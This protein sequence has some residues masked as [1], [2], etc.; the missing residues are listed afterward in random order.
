MGDAAGRRAPAPLG[1]S[2]S[3]I[4]RGFAR[5]LATL[6]PD[7]EVPPVDLLPA[8]RPRVAPYIYSPAEIAAL[9]HAAGQ[10]TPPL[11]AASYRT[12]IGL[13]AATGLRL[14][15]ALGLDRQTSTFTTARC[16][17]APGRPSSARCRCTRPHQGAARVRAPA[18]SALA[19]AAI[20][21]VLPQRRGPRLPIRVQPHLRAS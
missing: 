16:T 17:C 10:L 8:R 11:R 1:G 9:M 4:V 19:A 5:Y 12:V 21:G 3:T 20:A 13:M 18:R 14:G 2:G 6:D 7:S 15:E